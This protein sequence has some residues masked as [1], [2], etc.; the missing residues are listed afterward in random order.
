[1][2]L[3]EDKKLVVSFCIRLMLHGFVFS[4]HQVP[5][6]LAV[7]SGNVALARKLAR[8][9]IV[10]VP[11]RYFIVFPDD[12][13]YPMRGY[14]FP[15][16]DLIVF[17]LSILTS[18]KLLVLLRE[19]ICRNIINGMRVGHAVLKKDRK[20]VRQ[21]TN[22]AMNWERIA[23]RWEEQERDWEKTLVQM[24]RERDEGRRLFFIFSL[25]HGD[26]NVAEG[27]KED[28]IDW[29]YESNRMKVPFLDSARSLVGQ[30]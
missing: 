2:G 19:D 23:K 8:Y 4:V 5:W 12:H 3:N 29:H 26:A 28:E 20:H 21:V 13:C 25:S 6:R 9:G 14:H 30:S 10:R 11:E 18:D 24:V 17:L 7:A 1:M 27:R 16:S 22:N 15:S